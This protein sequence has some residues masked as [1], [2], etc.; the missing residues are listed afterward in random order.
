[1]SLVPAAKPYI[2]NRSSGMLI[3]YSLDCTLPEPATKIER[4]TITPYKC[5]MKGLSLHYGDNIHTNVKQVI[6][7]YCKHCHVFRAPTAIA[8]ERLTK[9]RNNIIEC[10]N[11]LIFYMT[12]G[13]YK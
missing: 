4:F 1:M 6:T 3:E 9:R 13:P 11:R 12:I 7:D 5:T 8:L 10:D 2:K